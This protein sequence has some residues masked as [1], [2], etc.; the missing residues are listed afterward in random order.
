V[1][2]F[3]EVVDFV[4][5]DCAVLF[6]GA[7]VLVDDDELDAVVVLLDEALVVSAVDGVALADGWLGCVGVE[8][9]PLA[10]LLKSES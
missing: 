4:V 2:D 1:L 8:A 6:A 10:A 7:E 9:V 3:A 5:L